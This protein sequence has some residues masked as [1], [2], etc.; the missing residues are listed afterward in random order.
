MD[1]VFD[2]IIIGGGPGGITA[3]I[4]AKRAGL[5]VAI[6][7][8]NVPG[9]A[10]STTADVS[11][12]TGFKSIDGVELAGKM[13]DHASSLNIPF[14]W[15]EVKKTKL[16]G[17]EKIVE[18]YQETY[19]AKA[20]IIAI[21]ASVRKLNLKK[22]RE[23][24]G[25]GVSYCATCDGSLYKGKDVALVGG[26]NTALEDCLYLSNIARK[27]YLI[28]RRDEFRGQD[29]L[30][31]ELETKNNVEFVLNSTVEEIIGDNK[32][33][34]IKV[35]NKINNQTS[36]INIDALFICIGR[37]P[38][39]GMIDEDVK[40]NEKDYII[41]DENMKTNIDG[42]YAIGDIR[43]SPLKQ[44][45]CACSDGAIAATKAFEYIKTSA[46]KLKSN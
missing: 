43:C 17:D 12:Y 4:Y 37:G 31:K 35:L 15:D 28:H 23:L 40:L 11:N 20:I 5:N 7:E 41:T 32:I 33:N 22:E 3:G 1:K 26:G 30:V 9:G 19:K 14:I 45:L 44:I 21:G 24:L 18:C 2:V 8:R 13:F 38:D 6:I 29:I 39:T 34:S 42:V 46:R 16:I 36:N 25:K 10:I 27:V